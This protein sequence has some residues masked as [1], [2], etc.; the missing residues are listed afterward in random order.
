MKHLK[1]LLAL[2]LALV[3]CMALLPAALAEDAG[4]IAP[5]PD[6]PQEVFSGS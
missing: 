4:T 1:R 2:L 5:A 3:L 6:E